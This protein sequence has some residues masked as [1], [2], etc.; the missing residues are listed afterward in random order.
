MFCVLFFFRSLLC[1]P[2]P[3]DVGRCTCVI[4]KEKSP[5]G[6]R[7]GAFYS[8]YTNVSLSLSHSYTTLVHEFLY[9][10]SIFKIQI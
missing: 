1:R 9:F 10:V 2:L 7:G 3:V 5:D 8:L 4:V 6:L